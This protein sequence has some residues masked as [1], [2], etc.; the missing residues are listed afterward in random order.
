MWLY[1]ISGSSALRLHHIR[2]AGTGENADRFFLILP[3]LSQ[4][5]SEEFREYYV[6][7]PEEILLEETDEIAGNV[8]FTGYTKEYVK[9]AVLEAEGEENI[10]VK[11]VV[12]GRIS[13]DVYR[14]ENIEKA[15]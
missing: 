1:H 8:Y 3:A 5:M 15:E 2:S 11:G 7:R 12:T 13:A 10:L 9:I 4:E 6:G 14:M